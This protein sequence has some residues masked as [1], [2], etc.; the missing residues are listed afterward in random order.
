MNL[1]TFFEMSSSVFKAQLTTLWYPSTNW[2]A[3]INLNIPFNAKEYFR[4]AYFRVT[5]YIYIYIYI[6]RPC[7]EW[8]KHYAMKTYGEVEV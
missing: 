7:A 6:S 5:I 3:G 2:L 8:I 1:Q 4:L